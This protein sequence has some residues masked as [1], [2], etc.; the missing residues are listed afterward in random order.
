MIYRIKVKRKG[1]QRKLHIRDT[2]EDILDELRR[3]LRTWK[4]KY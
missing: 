2:K 4:K 3:L 1:I